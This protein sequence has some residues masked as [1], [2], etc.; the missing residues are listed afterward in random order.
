V[1][2]FC[3]GYRLDVCAPTDDRPFFFNQKRIADVGEKPP[4]GYLY[5]ID[6]FLV[7]MLT[8]AVLLGLAAVAFALPLLLVRDAGRPGVASLAFFAAIGLGFLLL[9]VVLIQR[10]VLFLGFPT[11]ALSVVL[12][13]LLV[14]TGLG[15]LLSSRF[16]EPR[17]ALVAA[18]GGVAA[19]IA[20]GAVGLAPLL[21]ELI[22]L[23]FA[24]RVAV[25]VLLLAPAA[26]GMG[27][28]MPIGL[29]RL[30]GLHPGGVPWAWGINGVMS[31]LASVLAVALSITAGFTVAMLAAC[32]C[33]LAALAHAV[34]GRWPEAPGLGPAPSAPEDARARAPAEPQP[35]GPGGSA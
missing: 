3:S 29:R 25:T 35:I 13:A 8:L 6:P 22:E 27:M 1:D 17:R 16:G 4:P 28:A 7:L 2:A 11:Y 20:V 31:V 26:V 14:F 9:E 12:F 21:R 15:A 34:L 24:A 33:Y 32:A 18:L 19:L 23:P 30:A 10:F 5:S